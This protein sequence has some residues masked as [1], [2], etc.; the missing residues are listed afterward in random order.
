[1]LGF[2]M[3]AHF[4]HNHVIN[5]M[6]YSVYYCGMVLAISYRLIANGGMLNLPEN[7]LQAIGHVLC[8]TLMHCIYILEVALFQCAIL[9]HRPHTR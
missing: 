2:Y 5:D 3:A 1:M 6:S 9:Y 8:F 7:C 4:I